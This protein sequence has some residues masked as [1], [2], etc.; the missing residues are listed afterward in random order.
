MSKDGF[1]SER[2]R[3][4]VATC[5]GDGSSSYKKALYESDMSCGRNNCPGRVFF[6]SGEIPGCAINLVDGAQYKRK[7][8]F[9]V[10]GFPV[11]LSG[12]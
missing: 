3:G 6:L 7:F 1:G 2:E 9:V 8:S 12:D 4:V 5:L 11:N 10:L